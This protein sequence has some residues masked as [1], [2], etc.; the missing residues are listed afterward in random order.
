M[1]T[2]YVIA[3]SFQLSTTLCLAFFLFVSTTG[4]FGWLVAWLVG[5]PAG[6]GFARGKRI[7]VQVIS[8]YVPRSTLA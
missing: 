4:G 3:K 1:L 8:V 2:T 7:L 5:S 6:M